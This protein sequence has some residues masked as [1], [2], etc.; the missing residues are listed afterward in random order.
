MG[1]NPV[2]DRLDALVGKWEMVI[3]SNGQTFSGG[4]AIFVWIEE[5][6]FLVYRGETGDASGVPAEMIANSPLP[7]VSVI[8]LDD[9]SEQFMMLYSDARGV[10]RVYQMTLSDGVW[11]LWRD[12]PRFSQRYTGTV[13]DE[14][15]TITGSWEKSVDDAEWEHDFDL[16]YTRVE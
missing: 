11:K 10:F 16:T 12:T 8:G 7:T 14:G 15:E 3:S 1:L 9:S 5:R 6:A 2:L 4:H 13:S